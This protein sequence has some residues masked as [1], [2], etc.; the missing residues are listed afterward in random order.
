MLLWPGDFYRYFENDCNRAHKPHPGEDEHN[1]VQFKDSST[2][3]LHR[4]CNYAQS[5][6]EGFCECGSAGGLEKNNLKV[7]WKAYEGKV[8]RS[9]TKFSHYTKQDA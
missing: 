1:T 6:Q 4:A 7:Y 9:N 2:I 3:S 5:S 8:K